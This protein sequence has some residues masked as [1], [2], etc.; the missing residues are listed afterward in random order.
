MENNIDIIGQELFNKIRSRFQNL[1]LGNNEGIV[2]NNPS[3]ARFFDFE[4]TENN[5]VLG[6]ISVSL[7]ENNLAVMY[8][9]NF[10]EQENELRG[11]T[12]MRNPGVPGHRKR[13]WALPGRE[14]LP[15]I[16]K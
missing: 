2:T 3:E 15:R 11:R 1:T 13:S 9:Q 12:R 5:N 7:D 14:M 6:N 10:L 16:L 4:Y 8:Q